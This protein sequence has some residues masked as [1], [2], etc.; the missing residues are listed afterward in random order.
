MTA[1]QPKPVRVAGDRS[2]GDPFELE[3]SKIPRNGGPPI[4]EAVP[5]GAGPGAGVAEPS[6]AS[7]PTPC[8]TQLELDG[9]AWDRLVATNIHPQDLAELVELLEINPTVRSTALMFALSRSREV[10]EQVVSSAS[11]AEPLVIGAGDLIVLTRAA[12]ARLR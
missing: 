11:V 7:A 2:H 5:L 10:L 9:S 6:G 12:M 3:T 4:C 8:P 1:L